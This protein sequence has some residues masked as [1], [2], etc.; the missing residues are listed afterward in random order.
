MSTLVLLGRL[1]DKVATRQLQQQQDQDSAWYYKKR[2]FKEFIETII[3]KSVSIETALKG[4][5]ELP[6][7]PKAFR[8]MSVQEVAVS[9]QL[10]EQLYEE[11]RDG[12]LEPKKFKLSHKKAARELELRQRLAEAYNIDVDR[13]KAKVVTGYY[14][15]DG[16]VFPY[17]IEAAIAPRKDWKY[18]CRPGDLEFIGYMNDSPAIDGGEKYFSD[19]SYIWKDKKSGEPK[20]ATSA[21]EILQKCGFGDDLYKSKRRIPSVFL[22]NLLTPLPEWLGAA[23]KTH[24]NLKPYA[25]DIAETVSC[26]AYYMPTCHGQGFA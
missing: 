10:I 12:M 26:L 16:I 17:A 13:A 5:R 8:E 6:C 18:R 15:G 3:D 24:I 22:I 11:L 14:D 1:F 19:G 4:F 21:R 25:K 2:G 20:T 23:G 7:L 9:P